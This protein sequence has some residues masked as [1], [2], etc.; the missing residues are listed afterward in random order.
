MD[1]SLFIV[2]PSTITR[3]GRGLFTS[4]NIHKGS[5]VLEYKGRRQKYHSHK[6]HGYCYEV[7]DGICINATKSNGKAK[8]VN[9]NYGYKH[10][11][12]NLDWI[13]TEGNVY[14]LST[15]FIHKGSELFVN[16]GS[17]YWKFLERN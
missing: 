6:D 4:V 16:Y 14:L 10:K 2:K 11:L 17:N 5:T 3:A 15:R 13:I 8:Y 9:D 12:Y 1:E 7:E